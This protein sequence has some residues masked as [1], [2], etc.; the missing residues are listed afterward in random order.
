VPGGATADPHVDRSTTSVEPAGQA[1]PPAGPSVPASPAASIARK[2]ASE[3]AA[4]DP[5]AATMQIALHDRANRPIPAGMSERAPKPEDS[6]DTDRGRI[7]T[8]PPM[9][10]QDDDDTRVTF[11]SWD[12]PLV[13]P[14][15]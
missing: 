7:T 11:T 10:Q 9:R 3:L 4:C 13:P 8:P 1:D 2:G 5:H 12:L 15:S 14:R 6:A